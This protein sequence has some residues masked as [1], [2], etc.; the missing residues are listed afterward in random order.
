MSAP[1]I[2]VIGGGAIGASCAWRLARAGHKVTIVSDT[3][4]PGAS[5]V[6]AGMLAPVTEAEYGEEALFRLNLASS[7]LFP[8]FIDELREATDRDCGYRRCGTLLVARDQD[9]GRAI[10]EIHDFQLRLGVDAKRVSGRVARDLEPALSPRIRSGVLVDGDHQIDPPAFVDALHSACEGSGVDRVAGRVVQV[11]RGAVVLDDGAR[12]T[13]GTV[14]VAAGAHS[15]AIAGLPS[16]PVRP[17]KGQLVHLRSRGG[18][19]LPSRNIRGL[20]VYVVTR[21]DG[22][23]VIGATVEEQGFDPTLTAQAA[24]DLLRDAYEIVPG[25]LELEFVR[26]TAGF[27]PATP[28]NAP[29]IGWL[30]DG[31]IAATGHYRNGVL[32]SPIT[33]RSVTSLVEGQTPDLLQAFDPHRFARTEARG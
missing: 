11:E 17:V 28:D 26:M 12:L 25:L 29:V 9:D 2:I 21:L 20:D 33:A 3:D 31:V 15:N 23:V 22:R 8:S 14:V 10:E 27:R 32:Q 19:P 5:V 1:D 13:C 4:V 16:I 24:H 6:A 7:E 30:S 18:V